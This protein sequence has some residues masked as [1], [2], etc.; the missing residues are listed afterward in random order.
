MVGKLTVNCLNAYG[1]NM[2]ML[3]TVT[4]I[5]GASRIEPAVR[6][7][8]VTGFIT[9]S[10]LVALQPADDAGAFPRHV[11]AAARSAAG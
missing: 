7:L 2:T 10:V 8:F 6:V 1:G 9:A 4:S 3:T 5:S 11:R